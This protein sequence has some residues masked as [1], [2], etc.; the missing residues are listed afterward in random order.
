MDIYSPAKVQKPPTQFEEQKN[1]DKE[2]TSIRE[3]LYFIV[4]DHLDSLCTNVDKKN[5]DIVWKKLQNALNKSEDILVKST[6][7][8]LKEQ[9][10]NLQKE[11]TSFINLQLKIALVKQGLFS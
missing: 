2:F 9:D 6:F 11:V 3:N 7:K 1:A 5:I 8:A 4:K 10:L